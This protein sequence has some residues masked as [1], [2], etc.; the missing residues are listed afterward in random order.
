MQQEL[1]AEGHNVAIIIVNGTNAIGND[2]KL[3]EKGAVP[4]LQDAVDIEAW[5]LHAGSKDDFFI[6]TADHVLYKALPYG[7]DI[8][9]VLSIEANYATVKQ[10]AI[11]AAEQ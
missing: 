2:D 9:I 11:E 4:V 6:Y 10:F 3:S 8:S 5:Q 7:G 1:E